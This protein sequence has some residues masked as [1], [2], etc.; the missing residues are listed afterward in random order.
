MNADDMEL[1]AQA[2]SFEKV[3]NILNEN[4]VRVQKYFKSWFFALN[5]NINR[6]V[7]LPVYNDIN[8][9]INEA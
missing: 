6:S 8:N 2:E 1:A 4:L 5:P 9:A 3:E 7:S